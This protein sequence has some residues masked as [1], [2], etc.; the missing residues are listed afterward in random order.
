MVQIAFEH[1]GLDWR[2]YVKQD[3]RLLRPAD[4][5]GLLGIQPKQNSF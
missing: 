1:L 5:K 3:Q 2:Q 4:Q